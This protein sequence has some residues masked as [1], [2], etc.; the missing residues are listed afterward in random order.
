MTN[1]WANE[2]LHFAFYFLSGEELSKVFFNYFWN[3]IAQQCLFF[4]QN[5]NQL[6]V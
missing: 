5:M 3:I 6:Y 2:Q 4:L 1:H